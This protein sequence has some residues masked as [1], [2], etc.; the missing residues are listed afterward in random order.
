MYHTRTT[1]ILETV[2]VS[3]PVCSVSYLELTAYVP[4]DNSRYIDINVENNL[5]ISQHRSCDVSH[6]I[7]KLLDV[8]IHHK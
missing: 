4:C 8:N 2:V 3:K 7:D 1:R 6:D 5:G